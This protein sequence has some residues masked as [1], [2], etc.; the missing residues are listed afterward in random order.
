M[1]ETKIERRPLDINKLME[2]ASDALRDPLLTTR[3]TT[4]GSFQ[5]NAILSQSLKSFMR[6]SPGWAK[7][8]DIE[9]EAID[10]ISLKFSRILS[11]KS[12]E[13]Q[14]WEDVAG[15]AKLVE[16]QCP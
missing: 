2:G 4:H 14:H 12:M 8:T 3:Q 10:M 5:D 15:Y 9:R 6:A 13:R 1:L 7:L 16:D 11:G